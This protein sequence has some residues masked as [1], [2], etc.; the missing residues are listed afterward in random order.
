[1]T[2]P[3]FGKMKTIVIPFAQGE[4]EYMTL[5]EYKEKTGVDIRD[6][7]ILEPTIE[8]GIGHIIPRRYPLSYTLIQSGD[9]ISQF[10]ECGALI[11]VSGA[12]QIQPWKSGVTDYEGYV[13]GLTFDSSGALMGGIDLLLKID[14]DDE[15]SL[16]NLQIAFGEI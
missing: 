14:K 4:D 6:V 15:F 12:D 1:M 3:I 11:P 2:R 10:G 7:I 8:L 13:V 5:E 16:E 9:E